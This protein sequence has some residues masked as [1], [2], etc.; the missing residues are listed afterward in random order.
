VR[1]GNPALRGSRRV[2]AGRMVQAG[3]GS[4]ARLA[5]QAP[6]GPSPQPLSR[7]ERGS[8]RA[9]L[10][11]L[12][13]RRP[14]AP[15]PSP[16]GRGAG[17]EGREPGAARVSPGSSRSHGAGGTWKRSET[18]FPRSARTLTPTPL[19][20]GE[21]LRPVASEGRGAQAGRFRGERGSGRADPCTFCL[22][23]P[24]SPQYAR[25][26]RALRG[27][28]A[29]DA[30]GAAAQQI[31]ASA[32]SPLASVCRQPAGRRVPIR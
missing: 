15:L 13:K 28:A 24:R 10:A 2:Q 18:R 11:L 26:R 5:F 6:P 12:R 21:G 32:A 16:L 1:V 9:A 29:L 8:G 3:P 4:A 31:A 17:G 14:R 25:F 27:G 22:C 19:P 7:G 23:G 30:I 20:G